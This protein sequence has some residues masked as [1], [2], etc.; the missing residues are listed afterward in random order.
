M[1]KALL[2]AAAARRKIA[3]VLPPGYMP[4]GT[5]GMAEHAEHVKFHPGLPT[6]S[7]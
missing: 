4:M 3:E 6:R 7:P 2:L 5:D 1:L